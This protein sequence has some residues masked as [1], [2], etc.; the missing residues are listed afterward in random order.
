VVFTQLIRRIPPRTDT[1]TQTLILAH[2]QELVQ[3]A[4]RHCVRAYPDKS[5]EIE[6]GKERATGVADIT[7]ASIQSINS[8]NRIEKFDPSHFKLVLVDEAHHAVSPTYLNVLK[9][10]NLHKVEEDSP[11]LVGVSATLLRNDGLGLGSVFDHIVYHKLV[12]C[13][14]WKGVC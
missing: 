11:V 2:R 3:Q 8:K 1:A 7:V 9:Y 5:V 12:S 10:F 6:L 14:S 4:F 13:S